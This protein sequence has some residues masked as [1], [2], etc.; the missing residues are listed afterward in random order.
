MSSEAK[1]ALLRRCRRVWAVAA[2]HGEAERLAALQEL[3]AERF[4]P[5]DRLVYLGNLLGRGA[6]VRETVDLA[7]AFRRRLLARPG[8]FAKDIAFLRGSQEEMWQKLLQ[9]QFAPNP[10]EV[11]GWMLEQGVGATIRAYGGDVEAGFAMLR[12]G[13][14]TV[15][16]WTG[17]L[18]AAMQAEP[19]HYALLSA[20][21]HAAYTDDGRLLFVHAGLDPERPLSAQ[22]DSLWWGGAGFARLEAPYGGFVRVVRGYDRAHAGVVLGDH[23][24]SLDAGCGFGGPLVAGCFDPEGSLVDLIEA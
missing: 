21:R 10:R 9:L 23:M 22:G 17:A 1:F 8:M 16:R 4:L 19:G 7:L 15:T 3:L 18:R 11:Y 24:A 12:D 2:V 20:L 13:A 14:L 6:R 5:G